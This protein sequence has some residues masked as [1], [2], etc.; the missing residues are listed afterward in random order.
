MRKII[1][2]QVLFFIS[3][4]SLSAFAASAARSRSAPSASGEYTFILEPYIG[5][6]RGYLTQK[7]IPEITTSGAGFGARLGVRF[8]GLGMGIDYFSG[9][10][11]AIQTGQSSD[12]KPT[13][14]GIF[15]KTNLFSD[16]GFFATYLLSTKALVQSE[17]NPSSFSGSGYKLGLVWAMYSM[18]NINFE[19]YNRTYNKYGET[20]LTNS[21]LSSTA[22]VSI[23]FPF[24]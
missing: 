7:G 5:Y 16:F 2:I 24:L 8:I 22:G 21:L 1:F 18:M 3:V 19:L 12:F 14:Y 20:S 13:E 15:I 23:S 6:E 9:S 11:T 4:Y 10:E 17:S